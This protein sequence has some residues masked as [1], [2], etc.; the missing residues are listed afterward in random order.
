M[1]SAPGFKKWPD[2]VNGEWKLEFLRWLAKETHIQTLVETGT[3][4][5]VTPY[6]LRNDFSQIYTIE[7]HPPLYE[8]SFHRLSEFKNIQQYLGSSKTLLR[9]VINE[10]GPEKPIL[11]WLDAHTCGPHTADDGDPLP[12][13]LKTIMKMCPEALIVIDDMKDAELEY[14]TRLYGTDFEGWHREYRRTVP[15][16]ATP[17]SA[18]SARAE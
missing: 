16:T 17:R 2:A 1:K 12:H 15:A 10:I 3:C 8:I 6:F 14:L 11:F 9:G 18:P 13:E 5:G 4:E 7:L